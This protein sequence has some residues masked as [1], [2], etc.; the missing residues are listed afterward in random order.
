MR[1]LIIG[2]LFSVIIISCDK[3]DNP[4]EPVSKEQ[5][6][7]IST[8]YL[9]TF[10][11][12]LIKQLVSSYDPTGFGSVM[13]TYDVDV[14]KIVY[15]TVDTK[16]QITIASGALFL[17]T[18]KNNL[19]IA[20]IQH[21][22]QTKRTSVASVNPLNGA[23]G[24]IG[25]SLGYFVVMPDYLGLGESVMVHPY[26]HQKTSAATVIDMIRAGRA[27]ASSKNI[28]LNGQVFLLGYSEGGYVTMAAQ[29]EIEK[30]YSNEI[31]LAA[32]APM[33]GAYDLNLTAQ[34]IIAQSTYNQPS[35]L[36]YFMA[37]YDQIYGW[38]KLADIFNSPYAERMNSLFDGTKTTTEINAQ[39]TSNIAQLFKQ[40]FKDSYL[41]G[42]FKLLTDAFNENSLLNFKPVTP[43]KLFH[44]DAD[45]YVPYENSERARDYFVS[46]GV[47]VEL[48]TVK[49]GTHL[50]SAVP[51][52]IA[53][54]QWFESL[55]LK[56]EYKLAGNW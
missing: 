43:T 34:K 54:I 3:S 33:A 2:L 45:E 50:S 39:L 18:G 26:H 42:T 17:P 14:F 44:G 20:S 11:A 49:G 51:S 28:S 30:K 27:Y 48:I 40:S 52:V 10:G 31:K 21:G 16:G 56:K 15:N 4:V 37:A 6:A 24:L 41:N 25:A 1:N 35:Y 36:A 7:L 38:N 22:T 12:S 47:N 55:R 53:A 23:E 8:S 9:G 5:G 46:Q 29:K 19:S 13:F 32:S